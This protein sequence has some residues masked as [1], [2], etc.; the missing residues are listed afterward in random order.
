MIFKHVYCNLHNQFTQCVDVVKCS[1]SIIICKYHYAHIHTHTYMHTYIHT[2]THTY[3]HIHAH[4]H[5]YN[6]SVISH[7]LQYPE[8]WQVEQHSWV[9]MHSCSLHFHTKKQSP[10]LNSIY[11]HLI[12]VHDINVSHHLTYIY[13]Y[14]FAI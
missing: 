1:G 14:I 4:T 2:H 13:I 9:S 7:Y 8:C 6:I 12:I 3:A 11:R 10:Q 5:A